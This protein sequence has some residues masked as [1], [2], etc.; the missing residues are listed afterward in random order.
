MYRWWELENDKCD[1]DDV[2]GY[3]SFHFERI[4]DYEVSDFS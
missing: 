4:D 2:E 1:S 3:T